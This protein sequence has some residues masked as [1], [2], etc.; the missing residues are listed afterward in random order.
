[1]IVSGF[2]Q[3]AL[4]AD[5]SGVEDPRSRKFIEVFEYWAL[6]VQANWHRDIGWHNMTPAIEKSTSSEPHF[7]KTEL[8][9]NTHLE[10]SFPGH[11]GTRYRSPEDDVVF[12]RWRLRFFLLYGA[13]ALLL[14]GGVS[15]FAD[16]Q[17]KATFITATATNNPAVTS[18]DAARRPHR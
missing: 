3:N 6:T 11:N 18:A 1:L 16:R 5:S 12:R 10:V 9:Q 15:I 7:G 4:V 13:M 14:F 17:G 8:S 2:Q